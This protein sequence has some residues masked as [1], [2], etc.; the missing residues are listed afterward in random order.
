MLKYFLSWVN[1][2]LNQKK[3]GTG[4]WD[5]VRWNW[6]FW[7]KNAYFRLK[8]AKVTCL[9][10]EFLKNVWI[11]F[12]DSKCNLLKKGST[13]I[14]PKRFIQIYP[15]F[16]TWKST[17]FLYLPSQQERERDD[18]HKILKMGS[19]HWVIILCNEIQKLRLVTELYLQK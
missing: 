15:F 9:K 3:W 7:P 1:C 2:T 19:L 4:S 13:L 12:H 16:T 18:P 17:N 8:M 11:I 6:S 10:C 5:V 14:L